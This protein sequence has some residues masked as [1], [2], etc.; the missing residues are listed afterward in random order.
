MLIILCRE[1]RFELGLP[2]SGINEVEYP[3]VYPTPPANIRISDTS[4]F[5]SPNMQST[6]P[7]FSIS[8]DDRQNLELGWFFYLAEIALKKIIHNVVSWLYK[9]KSDVSSSGSNNNDHYL[10]AGATEFENQIQQWWVIL[11]GKV[12]F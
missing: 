10:Q 2:G 6:S 11:A 12:Y 9:A 5:Q 8:N 1:L 3:H 4:S 7:N